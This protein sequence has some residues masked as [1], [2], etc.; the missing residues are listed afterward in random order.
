MEDSSGTILSEGNT[1]YGIEIM[2]DPEFRGLRLARRLYD[3][4]KISETV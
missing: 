2:V 4:R 3:A 1:L